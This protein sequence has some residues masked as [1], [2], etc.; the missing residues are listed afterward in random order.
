MKLVDLDRRG[1]RKSPTP[2]AHL[3]KDRKDGPSTTS[4][5]FNF[6]VARHLATILCWDTVSISPRALEILPVLFPTAVQPFLLSD[7][8]SGIGS[9][10]LPRHDSSVTVSIEW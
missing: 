2:R 9:G 3:C 10:G 4:I 7:S 5:R 8:L 1:G 6:R